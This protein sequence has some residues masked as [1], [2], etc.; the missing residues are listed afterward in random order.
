MPSLVTAC[1]AVKAVSQQAGDTLG[2]AIR[3]KVID[4]VAR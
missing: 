4:N 1:T 2:K 3:Q